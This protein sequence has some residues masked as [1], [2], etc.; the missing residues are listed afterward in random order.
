M[1]YHSVA[2]TSPASTASNVGPTRSNITSS[3]SSKLTTSYVTKAD[4]TAAI[5]QAIGTL[6]AATTPNIQA[7]L[8]ALQREV[9]LTNS[10]NNLAPTNNVALTISNPTVS[11]PSITGGSIN[12]N[13]LAVSG[14]TSLSGNLTVGGNFN[15]GT[16]SFSIASTTNLT[17]NSIVGSG[18]QPTISGFSVNGVIN[19]E[20]Y[21]AK[22]DG[23]TDDTAAFQ[24]ALNLG[25]TI[26]L[27]AHATCISGPLT[28]S[29]NNTTL[30][31]NQST[32]KL[33]VA[34]SNI[35]P[36]A[37]ASG[38]TSWC[39]ALLTIG[40]PSSGSAVISGVTIKNG[41][42]DGNVA[43]QPSSLSQDGILDQGGTNLLV[44]RVTSQNF[45][46]N[47][48]FITNTPV[49]DGA[50]T[51]T[52]GSGVQIVDNVM[53]GDNVCLHYE[54]GMNSPV[55][56]NNIC[57]NPS[58]LGIGLFDTSY[59]E[60]TS[61][62]IYGAGTTGGIYVYYGSENTIT[63]NSIKNSTGTGISI[64]SVHN[65]LNNNIV[66]GTGSSGIYLGGWGNTVNGGVLEEGSPGVV[67]TLDAITVGSTGF[68]DSGNVISNVTMY[69]GWKYGI[70]LSDTTATQ[71]V[72]N[73][74]SDTAVSTSVLYNPN[75]LIVLGTVPWAFTAQ[76]LGGPLDLVDIWNSAGNTK[77]FSVNSVGTISASGL[78]VSGGTV[79]AQ[80]FYATSGTTIGASYNVTAPTNGLS[81]Q[82]YVGIGT[83]SPPV[84]LTIDSTS[85]NGTMFRLSNA[86]TGGH[87]FDLLSTGSANTGGAG[88]LDIFD[89]TAGF[90]RLSIAANG[91]VGI[92]TTTPDRQLSI[93]SATTPSL[94]FSLGAGSGNQWTA[95]I[96]TA[97]GNKFKI[98]S[99][100]AVGTNTRL[101]IDGNGNLGIG[102]TS[103]LAKLDVAGT[104]NVTGPLFQLSSV[105]SRHHHRVHCQ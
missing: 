31:L 39:G 48:I 1:I 58:G 62:T 93:Y 84:P 27:P 2:S 78:T 32:L 59:A 67:N 94:E 19:P 23:V 57:L 7:Q 4:L 9:A 8:D 69:G 22:C 26:Q 102:T 95:G 41:I 11:N 101:T 56:S 70:D 51:L 68:G 97:D 74:I 63:S 5:Q 43:S 38:W 75:N 37:P 71:T 92:G 65:L 66:N 18:S 72:V 90:A 104:N 17:T 86:S 33:K 47:G 89:R 88:R 54:G 28:I 12:T 83:T 80:N 60:V 46:R 79:A 16:V 61:N 91:N 34:A 81:V 30:D 50:A 20:A 3:A 55:L 45:T 77:L 44:T 85:A 87:I 76:S 42:L 53:Q 98:A 100:S 14:D 96:D 21:G 35:C 25:G 82:G 24:T 73:G 49:N 29:Q 99:S 40:S 10:I 6:P 52:Q 64:A 15:A 13:S 36:I 103:P 105:S